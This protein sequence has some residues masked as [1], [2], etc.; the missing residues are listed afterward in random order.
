MQA[1][2]GLMKFALIKLIEV[3]LLWIERVAEPWYVRTGASEQMMARLRV[4][5][6]QRKGLLEKLGARPEINP[7]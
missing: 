1:A 5:V 4:Q 2:I 6:E 3:D 7:N